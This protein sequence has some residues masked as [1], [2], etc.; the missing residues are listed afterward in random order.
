MKLI[1]RTILITGG[2][3]GIG[4]EMASILAQKGNQVIICSRSIEKLEKAVQLIP[5]LEAFQCDLSNSGERKQLVHR[6]M[7]QYPECNLLINNAAIVHQTDF[8]SDQDMIEKA[9]LEIETNF[10]AP[11]ELTKMF[12]P[13]LQKNPD[14]AIIFI[15]TGLVYSPKAIYPIYCA[16]KSALHSFIQTLRWQIKSIPIDIYEVLM[17]AVD[18]P[19]HKGNPPKMAIPT[20]KA[21]GE[22]IDKLEKNQKNIR[23]GPVGVLY[24]L[25]R[26]APDFAMK[27]VNS[28]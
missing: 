27:K 9:N 21:V 28:F 16:T 20:D 23:I 2:S 13:H 17:P 18:T 14:S 7:K 22:M 25:S 24:Y 6:M 15:T 26:I 1:D 4:L 12:S 5:G 8:F 19:F 11:V 10:I 3:S